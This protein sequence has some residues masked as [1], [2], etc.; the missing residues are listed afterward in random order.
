MLLPRGNHVREKGGKS[1]QFETVQFLT[2]PRGCHRQSAVCR[3]THDRHDPR[4]NLRYRLHARTLGG[5]SRRVQINRGRGREKLAGKMAKWRGI[6]DSGG[7]AQHVVC[8]QSQRSRGNRL[9][10]R[11]KYRHLTQMEGKTPT[12]PSTPPVMRRVS[13]PRG[14]TVIARTSPSCDLKLCC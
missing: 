6:E 11:G 8:V 7:N 9:R 5:K 3:A 12:F 10:P 4:G 13:S 2:T 1:E 14:K